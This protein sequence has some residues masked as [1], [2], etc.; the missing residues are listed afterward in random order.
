MTE[1]EAVQESLYPIERDVLCLSL[2]RRSLASRSDVAILRT[3]I[4]K[5]P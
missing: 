5:W 2:R 3:L 4:E 1:Q